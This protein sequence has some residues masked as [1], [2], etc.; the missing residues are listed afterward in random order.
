MGPT[1]IPA[2]SAELLAFDG[3]SFAV[4]SD[5]EILHGV[6]LSV[7]P[8][9]VTVLAGP[10]GAGKSTLLRLGNRLEVPSAG[11]VRFRGEDSA[12]IDPR[13][14]RRR[15]GMVFQKPVPFA[16]SVRT[17]LRVGAPQAMLRS[18]PV[19][20]ASLLPQRPGLVFGEDR[21]RIWCDYKLQLGRT[22][23]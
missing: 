21:L 5:R 19:E 7:A 9:A 6:S 16:G 15:V 17:N 11:S 14:L 13:E 12:V 18:A 23:P 3:V 4:D 2:E 10:S 22:A 20:L 8:A 1:R